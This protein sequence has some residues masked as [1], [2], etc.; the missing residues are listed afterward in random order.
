[1]LETDKRRNVDLLVEHFW[2]EG[3]LSL[4]RKFG[5]YLP[6]P[7][8]IGIYDVDVVARYQKDYALGITVT[9]DDLK[10]PRFLE[11]VVYLATRQTRFSNRQ[12]LLFIG[13]PAE[14][15]KKTNILLDSID[16]ETK[17]N[18]RIFRIVEKPIP[19]VKKISRKELFFS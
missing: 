9:V 17:K 2:R 7:G 19:S 13:I 1:M 14:L 8:R 11:R 10:D 16:P 3:Y 6:E 18:I 12:V 15:Y 5:R 4:S